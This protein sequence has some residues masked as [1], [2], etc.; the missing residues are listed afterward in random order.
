MRLLR[1]WLLVLA[2]LLLLR[3]PVLL[4]LGLLRRLPVLVVLRL[5]AVAALP[6]PLA[7]VAELRLLPVVLVAHQA[8]T[9]LRSCWK[10][11]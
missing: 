5:L 10:A 3:L 8:T 6:R 1:L 7:L 9:A 4:G 2:V 11:V